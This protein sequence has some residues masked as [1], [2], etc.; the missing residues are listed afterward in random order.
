M[1]QGNNTVP[2]I[3]MGALSTVSKKSQHIFKYSQGLSQGIRLSISDRQSEISCELVNF[4]SES[5]QFK[6]ELKYCLTTIKSNL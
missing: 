4:G 2:C 5:S 3:V 1:H 6:E